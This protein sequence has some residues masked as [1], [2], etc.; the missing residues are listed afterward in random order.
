M[1]P[2]K[3][4]IDAEDADGAL[5]PVV[6]N[7]PVKPEPNDEIILAGIDATKLSCEF[8]YDTATMINESQKARDYNGCINTKQPVDNYRQD[9]IDF[10]NVAVWVVESVTLTPQYVVVHTQLT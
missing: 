5:E 1:I 8:I 3:V 10:L 4:Y 9:V 6:T 2:V 7:L